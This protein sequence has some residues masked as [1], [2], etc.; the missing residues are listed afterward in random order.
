MDTLMETLSDLRGLSSGQVAALIALGT[1]ALQVSF[2]FLWPIILV[3]F[4]SNR[5]SA[6]TWQVKSIQ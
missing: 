2:S 3:G 5:E 6:V 4:I 1:I